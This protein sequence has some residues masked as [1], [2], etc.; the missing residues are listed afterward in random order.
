[1]V[2]A[3]LVMVARTQGERQHGEHVHKQATFKGESM[4]AHGNHGLMT[5][6]TDVK[7]SGK[8]DVR[9]K[10]QAVMARPANPPYATFGQQHEV[11]LRQWWP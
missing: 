1:M 6:A 9:L 2:E 7:V 5:L 10:P 3:G 8:P 11:D 4:V